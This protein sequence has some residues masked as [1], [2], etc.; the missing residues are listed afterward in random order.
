M[1]FAGVGK[2]A[3]TT[4]AAST[5]RTPVRS[6]TPASANKEISETKSDASSIASAQHHKE[7]AA[8][9]T[10]AHRREAGGMGGR[11][12]GASHR[13]GQVVA[14]QSSV[15]SV[16]DQEVKEREAILAKEAEADAEAVMETL[17]DVVRARTCVYF[18]G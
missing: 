10:S 16:N 15:G 5:R 18:F 14:V 1:A 7:A 12:S 6:Q 9:S 11:S 2:G 13:N 8:T 4:S 3:G 17:K